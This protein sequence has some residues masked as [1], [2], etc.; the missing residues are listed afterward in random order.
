MDAEQTETP[1]AA[2]TRLKR[3]IAEHGLPQMS[4][5]CKRASGLI[6]KY[7]HRLPSPYA[8]KRPSDEPPH[9]SDEALRAMQRGAP[10]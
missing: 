7:G 10:E 9:L 2:L 1:E 8:A 5:A 3:E 4:D 6:D